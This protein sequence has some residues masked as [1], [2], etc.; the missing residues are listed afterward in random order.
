[1]TARSRLYI[2]GMAGPFDPEGRY[3]VRARNCDG[4]GADA[5]VR[6]RR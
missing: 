4:S 3:G 6:G 5:A 1:M 2:M